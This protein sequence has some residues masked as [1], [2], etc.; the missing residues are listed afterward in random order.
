MVDVKPRKFS[1]KTTVLLSLNAAAVLVAGILIASAIWFN[2]G[3]DFR[4]VGEHSDIIDDDTGEMALL[5]SVYESAASYQAEISEFTSGGPGAISS[6]PSGEIWSESAM[7]IYATADQD[8]C[9]GSGLSDIGDTYWQTSNPSVIAG[10]YDSARTWLGYETS[11]CRYPVVKGTGTTTIT[12]G[13]YDGRRKDSIEVTVLTP[14]VDQW[15]KDVLSIVNNIRASNGLGNLTWGTTCES[16]A[17]I[18][19]HEIITL[20]SHTRP[21]GSNWSTACPAPESG[22]KSGE[23]LA[24]GNAAVSPVSVVMLW[25]GSDSHRENIM[26]PDFSKLAVG[27]VYDP[28]STYKTYWSQFFSTY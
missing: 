7:T 10:F 4:M 22:G 11:S 14:P 15:K 24:M 18:R 17:N 6:V 20:Y 3:M 1:R 16:A 9:I 8:I 27:F 21:D 12:V 13:T 23:N 2:G 26:N 28:D 5:E 19:A 25:L